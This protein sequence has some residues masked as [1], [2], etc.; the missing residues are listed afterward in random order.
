MS[1]RDSATV[2][3]LT[4]QAHFYLHCLPFGLEFSCPELENPGST[5]GTE[6]PQKKD[7]CDTQVVTSAHGHTHARTPRNCFLY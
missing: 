1:E 6:T 3:V 7:S 4:G 2:R 5:P